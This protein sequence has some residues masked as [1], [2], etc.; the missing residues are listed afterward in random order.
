[1]DLH[2]MF[3]ERKKKDS[4]RENNSVKKRNR[5][6][7]F[8]PDELV[9]DLIGGEIIENLEA[10]PAIARSPENTID[11]NFLD[12][13]KSDDVTAIGITENTVNEGMEAGLRRAILVGAPSQQ[14]VYSYRRSA[15]ESD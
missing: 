15:A 12:E 8:L 9:E 6:V 5:K 13:N 7:E 11:F 4:S 10:D 14:S 2:Y 3:R 1:M